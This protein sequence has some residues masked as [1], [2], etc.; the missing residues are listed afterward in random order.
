MIGLNFIKNLFTIRAYALEEEDMTF[1]N[2]EIE[3]EKIEVKTNPDIEKFI[4]MLKEKEFT[5]ISDDLSL[6][7]NDEDLEKIL[8]FSFM[9]IDGSTAYADDYSYSKNDENAMPISYDNYLTKVQFL[10]NSNKNKYVI[11]ETGFTKVA[12]KEVTCEEIIDLINND[13]WE[14]S[15]F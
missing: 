8:H 14:Q 1:L 9:S 12:F 10:F 11:K 15:S 13:Y 2:E 5:V 7:E 6:D 4:N 3:E